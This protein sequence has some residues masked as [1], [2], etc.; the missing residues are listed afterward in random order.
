MGERVF[1]NINGNLFKVRETKYNYDVVNLATGNNFVGRLLF[2][3]ETVKSICNGVELWPLSSCYLGI[4]KTKSKKQVLNNTVTKEFFDPIPMSNYYPYY[5]NDF[6]YALYSNFPYSS[7]EAAEASYKKIT[8]TQTY[9]YGNLR[10]LPTQISTTTSD[11]S[12]SKITKNIYADQAST[13]T[14]LSALQ[15][16]N[17][18]SLVAQNNV[19]APMQVEQYLNNDLLSKQ[20]TVFKTGSVPNQILPDVI[21][22]AKGTANLEDRVVFLEYDPKGNPS[23]VMMKDGSKT[24]YFY[25]ND[26]QVIIKIENYTGASNVFANPMG[27]TAACTFINQYPTSMVSV[28]NYDAVNKQITSIVA[29]DCK[30][31]FY[32][33]NALNQLYQI[34][35]QLGNILQEFDHN[36]K[37]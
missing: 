9:T 20:R 25:N 30:T 3:P 28:Y 33:Y 19:A 31:S 12:K 4:Y 23:I 7:V 15:L 37:N 22:T 35:D 2:G 34:K 8:T 13:L 21:Q 10:G 29:P 1:K 5:V 17:A 6:D 24:K 26:N 16:A 36:Y 11:S 32:E 27:T 18:N 14:G